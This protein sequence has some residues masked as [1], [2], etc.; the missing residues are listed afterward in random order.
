MAIWIGIAILVFVSAVINSIATRPT[1]FRIQ[2]GAQLSVLPA[3]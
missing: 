1:N 2:R 3:L